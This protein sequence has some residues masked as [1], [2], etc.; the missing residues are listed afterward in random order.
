M[1]E[2]KKYRFPNQAEVRKYVKREY[3]F[4]TFSKYVFPFDVIRPEWEN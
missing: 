2:T 3:Q 1:G 4:C